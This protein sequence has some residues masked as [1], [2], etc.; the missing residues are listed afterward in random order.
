MQS[1]N[2]IFVGVSTVLVPYSLLLYSGMSLRS[3]YT[4]ISFFCSW[5]GTEKSLSVF[6]FLLWTHPWSGLLGGV[7]YQL[8]TRLSP[9]SWFPPPPKYMG[10]EFFGPSLSWGHKLLF[11]K[12]WGE[13]P[14][15]GHR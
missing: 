8:S 4:E 11:S 2:A 9:G 13:K 14:S 12:S 5:C 1:Q 10:G 6:L 15:G 7:F 3:V